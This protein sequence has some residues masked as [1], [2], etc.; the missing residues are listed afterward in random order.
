VS[1]PELKVVQEE[2]RARVETRPSAELSEAFDAVLFVNHPYGDPIIG[3]P[4]ELASLSH[5]DALA[6]YR[7]H[8]RPGNA[9]LVVAGDVSAQE[10]R[11][12]AEETYGEIS[13]DKGFVARE[14]PRP[15]PL[16]ADRIVE[17]R[18]PRVAQPSTRIAWLVPSYA[19]A[20]E[21]D[22]EALDLLAEILGGN[23]TSRLY[24]TLVRE[25]QLATSAGTWYQSSAV[26]DTRFAFYAVPRDG[27]ALE[28]I[29]ERALE[30]IEDLAK[31]GI[32]E[33]ELARAK[34]SLLGSVLFAQDSQS[35]L[36]RIFGAALTTGSTL[37]DVQTWPAQISA[38]T[39]EEVQEVAQRFLT[40]RATVTGRLLQADAPLTQ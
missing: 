10:I 37:E 27:V 6:F 19:T 4:D 39:A 29:E 36:A 32:S 30:V 20:K 23:N 38:V 11:D 33:N 16:R 31:N 5:E 34:T 17:L 24:T 25:E 9:L 35:S 28:T 40:G 1:A 2:R 26:D 22:G 12:L 3:W 13:D 15:Q 8:Y 7:D 21:G 14:R 18:D